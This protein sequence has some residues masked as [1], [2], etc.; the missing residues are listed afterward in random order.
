MRRFATLSAVILTACGAASVASVRAPP[1]P[2]P[3]APATPTEVLSRSC[4]EPAHDVDGAHFFVCGRRAEV[5]EGRALFAEDEFD[6]H[7]LE[8]YEAADGWVFFSM[9]DGLVARADTFTGALHPL[10]RFVSGASSSPSRGRAAFVARGSLWLSDGRTLTRAEVPG[11]AV[12]SAAFAD[13]SIGAAVL[14]DGALVMTADGGARWSSIDLGGDRALRVWYDDGLRVALALR[15]VLLGADASLTT[16]SRARRAPEVDPAGAA[17]VAA[18]IRESDSTISRLHLDAGAWASVDRTTLRVHDA[19]GDERSYEIAN[20]ARFAA[21]TRPAI[22]RWGP[23][24]AVNLSV[25]Q[26]T[27]WHRLDADG[28][29]TLIFGPHGMATTTI[30]QRDIVWSDDGRH[31]ARLGPCP[32]TP[33]PAA[34]E[35]SWRPSFGDDPDEPHAAP[36]TALCVLEDGVRRWREVAL[37]DVGAVG[38]RWKIVGMHGALAL[39]SN[40]FDATEY[41]VFDTASGAK[42]PVLSEDPSVHI[43]SIDWAHDGSLVGTGERCADG[44]EPVVLRGSHDRPLSVRAAPGAVGAV[45]FVDADR[46]LAL[47]RDFSSLWRTR[48]GGATWEA[49]ASDVA[50]DR[51]EAPSVTCDADGC[52]VGQRMR[53]RGWGPVA[54]FSRA[55][56]SASDVPALDERAEE[57]ARTRQA[58]RVSTLLCHFS[59]ASRPS[60]WSVGESR[61]VG[62]WPDGVAS[63]TREGP[64]VRASWWVG[65]RHGATAIPRASDDLGEQSPFQF[66]GAPRSL[67]FVAA[68]DPT[69]LFRLDGARAT[70]LHDAPFDDLSAWNGYPTGWQSLATG[71]GGSVI[72]TALTST[73]PS[74]LIA[75]LDARGA[76]RAWRVFV[77]RIEQGAIARR[78]AAWGMYSVLADGTATFASLDGEAPVSAPMWRT[79]SALCGAPATSETITLHT[80][81]GLHPAAMRFDGLSAA[82]DLRTVVE[83]TSDG[84]CLRAMT[85]VLDRRYDSSAAGTERLTG[86]YAL[87]LESLAGDAM[88]GFADNGRRRV[89]IRCS[90]T[91]EN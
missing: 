67:T 38:V 68:R 77:T 8:A 3:V 6:K 42:A 70:E 79:T 29:M 69:Q 83:L 76:V 28:R 56:L 20:D 81:T 23:N 62:A 54:P 57:G 46:A 30:L 24:L 33:P 44:C 25:G 40:D 60:P 32:T 35:E 58:D 37:P 82:D 21:Q 61:N 43:A 16:V 52:D 27:V 63:F 39:F 34:E 71:D 74:V 14:D 15:D 55:V 12:A 1:R 13:A 22:V 86:R 5:R 41:A 87:R 50:H 65:A 31:L 80:T 85:G 10:G 17:L 18:S 66:F 72:S 51:D 19:R 90:V 88:T 89:P 64:N 2:A 4:G 53:V 48:D 9:L 11:A 91:T 49:V 84:A 59:G 78:G 36:T 45:D 7:Y 47:A 75:R 26:S 73:P